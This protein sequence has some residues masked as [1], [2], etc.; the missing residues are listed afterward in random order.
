LLTLD[1]ATS[2]NLVGG[3]LNIEAAMEAVDFIKSKHIGSKEAIKYIKKRLTHKNP[4]IQLLSL[5]VFRIYLAAGRMRQELRQAFSVRV[6][7]TRLCKFPR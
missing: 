4:N 3:A 6:G 2:E 1:S 7:W 5:L